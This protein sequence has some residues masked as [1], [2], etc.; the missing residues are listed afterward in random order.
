M[1]SEPDSPI[2]KQ[3]REQTARRLSEAGK[4]AFALHPVTRN[5]LQVEVEREFGKAARNGDQRTGW[6][7]WWPKFALAGGALAVLAILAV[8]VLPSGKDKEVEQLAMKE[9]AEVTLENDAIVPT[10]NPEGKPLADAPVPTA[11]P[12][13]PMPASAE[14]ETTRQEFRFA[15][16]KQQTQFSQ[17]LAKAPTQTRSSRRDS[18]KRATTEPKAVQLASPP[19]NAP[20][21]GAFRVSITDE[22]ITLVDA[23]QSRYSG[24][25]QL[26]MPAVGVA[27]S[28]DRTQNF[29]ERYYMFTQ[30]SQRQ[31]VPVSAQFVAVGTN[32][33]TR[34]IVRFTGQMVTQTQAVP[35]QATA[36]ASTGRE[37]P[38][39]VFLQIQGTATL[40]GRQKFPVDATTQP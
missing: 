24:T 38:S 10:P 8:A 14:V 4:G 9:K 28:A 19:V 12:V 26:L 39:G 31:Q 13:S 15:A 18:E 21:Q 20:L 34:A 37:M 2:E 23:D 36:A 3:L 17:N 16:R 7:A 1:P 22:Q 25:L 5:A 40:G 27:K 32:L 11:T 30:G 6:L 35:A 33:T 29:Q